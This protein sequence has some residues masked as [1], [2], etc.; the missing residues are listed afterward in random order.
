M[1]KTNNN[2]ADRKTAKD[3]GLNAGAV[4][5]K[6]RGQTGETST[7]Q[8]AVRPDTRGLVEVLT[9]GQLKLCLNEIDNTLAY[10]VDGDWAVIN[11]FD[12]FFRR[13]SKRCALEGAV[14]ISPLE[15]QQIRAAF[16]DAGK[17]I[18]HSAQTER[19]GKEVTP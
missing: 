2:P 14:K 16:A 15:T 3:T 8:R 18:E 5:K 4:T 19:M 12:A 17:L 10:R 13:H 6:D 7:R 9:L 1:T 11:R